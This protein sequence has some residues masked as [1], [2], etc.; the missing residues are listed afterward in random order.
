MPG[1]IF[2]ELQHDFGVSASAITSIGAVY[3]LIYAGSQIF[4]GILTDKYGGV[5]IILITG[6]ILCLG[7]IMFP[8][9]DSIE[10]LYLSRA[11]IGFGASGMY[12][13]IIKETDSLFSA[14]NFAPLLGLFCLIGYGGGL[15]ATR[16]FRAIVDAVGWRR[17]LEAVSLIAVVMLVATYFSGRSFAR[18]YVAPSGGSVGRKT[19]NVL[20]NLKIY[21]LIIAGMI[22]FAIYFSMQ[23]TIGPKFIGDFLK[24]APAQATKYT[25]MMMMITM[26]MMLTSGYISRLIG[27]RRKPFLIFA[28]LNTCVSV[29]ILLTGT[30]FNFPSGCFMAACL[31]LAISAGFTPV[32]VSFIKELNPRDVAAVSVGVQNTASYVAVALSANLIGLILDLFKNKTFMNHDII[33]YPPE[34]Y[35][36]VFST[37]LVF[38]AI[39]LTAS[40]F[41]KETNGSCIAEH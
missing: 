25:F 4:I 28:S 33:L 31:M 12:L 17:A 5:R 38:A 3:L 1:T 14:R 21:P 16:P 20:K 26:T 23:A 9:A 7:S 36:A 30:L 24:V 13:C 27:N 18:Q 32:T 6:L 22:N 15:F 8:L 2:N 10:I 41:S 39:S 29:T 40:I 19:L 35:V 11:L 34:A 37:M